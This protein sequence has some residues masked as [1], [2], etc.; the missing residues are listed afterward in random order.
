[1]KVMKALKE[2]SRIR[3]KGFSESNNFARVNKDKGNT[4]DVTVYTLQGK[5]KCDIPKG[6]IIEVIRF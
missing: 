6:S 3:V 5:K 4:V 2:G 1:M